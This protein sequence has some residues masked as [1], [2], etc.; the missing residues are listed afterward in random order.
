MEENK[1][2]NGEHME[3]F[4]QMLGEIVWL[5]TQSP[6][7]KEFFI[8][9]LE[10]MVMRPL[11]MKQFFIY[12]AENN[13]PAAVVIWAKVSDEVEQ[14][15]MQGNVRMKASDWQSGDKCWVVD[16]IAPFGKAEKVIADVRKKIAPE[17]SLFYLK[18]NLQGEKT[19]VELK[20]DD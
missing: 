18:T 1:Q 6:L 5:M 4:G 8:S 11:A 17:G 3:T 9:E 7:H 20:S 19:V 12:R 10:S 14:R 16:V 13:Q 15:L 2:Q